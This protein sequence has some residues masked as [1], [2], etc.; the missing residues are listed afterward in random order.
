MDRDDV[1]ARPGA[2]DVGAA[3]AVDRVRP[4]PPVMMFAADEPRI[5]TPVETALALTLVKLATE[6]ES[7]T[8]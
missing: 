7:P 4:L 8:D 2:D 5:V 3:I 1:R 6:V